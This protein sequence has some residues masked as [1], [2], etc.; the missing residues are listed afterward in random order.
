MTYGPAVGAA[1]ALLGLPLMPWQ[2]LVADVALEVLPDGRWAYPTVVITVP[3]QAGKTTLVQAILSHRGAML[4][5]GR[6]WLSAQN[7]DKAR[8]RWL[9]MSGRMVRR[10]PKSTK[11]NTGNS[12]EVLF[13]LRTGSELRPFAPNADSMHSE[14]PDL[15]APDEIWKFTSA[16]AAALQQAY[17]P[18]MITKNAQELITSTQGTDE[19]EWLNELTGSGRATVLEQLAGGRLGGVAYF[20]WSVPSEVDGLPVERLD[21]ERLLDVVCAHHPAYGHTITRDAL[22]THLGRFKSDRQGYVRGYGN[23]RLGSTRPRVIPSGQWL[24][25]RTDELVPER[26]GLGVVVDENGQNVAVVAAGRLGSGQAV[27]EVVQVGPGWSLMLDG[28]EVSPAV[29]VRRVRSRAKVV[30]VATMTTGANRDLGDQLGDRATPVGPADYA[31]ACARFRSGVRELTVLHRGSPSLD[32]AMGTVAQR[33]VAGGLGWVGEG[34]PVADAA[35]L[36][37]WAVDHPSEVVGRFRVL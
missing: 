35:S 14:S 34:A 24:A 9:D 1:S 19:S 6:L 18:G 29:F 10:L 21:D 5:D 11:R 8:A 23:L 16:D 3:R 30:G 22:Q 36:A 2:Q 32:A 25:A 26:V 15:V 7:R 31:A 37:L 17:L 27:V 20:E 13:W 28:L 33:K 4:T 12:H